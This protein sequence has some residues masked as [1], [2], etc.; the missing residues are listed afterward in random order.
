MK[1][2]L[3]AVGLVVV[4]AGRVMAQEEKVL[5]IK[6]VLSIKDAKERETELRKLL[7]TVENENTQGVLKIGIA[8]AL[9]A[10]DKNTEA[11]AELDDIISSK[12][13]DNVKAEASQQKVNIYLYTIKDYTMVINAAKQVRSYNNP[14]YTVLSYYSEGVARRKN[15]DIAGAIAA[16][17]AGLAVKDV[18]NNVS[19]IRLAFNKAQL[20]KEQSD[21]KNVLNYKTPSVHYIKTTLNMIK[22]FDDCGLGLSKQLSEIKDADTI[23]VLLTKTATSPIASRVVI[24]EFSKKSE[25]NVEVISTLLKPAQLS[26]LDLQS[27]W[28][29]LAGIRAS[30]AGQIAE[31]EGAR[32]LAGIVATEMEEVGNIIK[33]AK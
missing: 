15:N 22:N 1:R 24:T 28:N 2:I 20:T 6:E 27:R 16:Y 5:P 13:N 31:N 19:L 11:L 17:S 25:G 10:Q 30:L 29:I 9:K 4:M 12:H 32:Q 18:P 33:G 7:P 23:V 3:V 26:V 14:K 21:Y 8:T